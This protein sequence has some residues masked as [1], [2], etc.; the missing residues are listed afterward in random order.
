M[1][2]KRQPRK[3][4][5]GEKLYRKLVPLQEDRTNEIISEAL[6]IDGAE[7]IENY[8]AGVIGGFLVGYDRPIDGF[9]AKVLKV[10]DSFMDA[11]EEMGALYNKMKDSSGS[12]FTQ[13]KKTPAKKSSAK[14]SKTTKEPSKD[15]S[16]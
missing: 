8:L 1:A 14:T 12:A 13:K 6:K 9:V 2:R 3:N 10:Q 5:E 7:S 15:E 11:S 16:A 4:T